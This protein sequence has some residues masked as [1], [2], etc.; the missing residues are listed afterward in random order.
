[1]TRSARPDETEFAPHYA[2][3]VSRV[4]DGDII[5][6]LRSQVDATISLARSLAE[7]KGARRYAPGKWSVREVLGHLADTERIMA[8]RALRVARGDATPLAGFDENA[9]VENARFDER[10][11][12]SLA[13]DLAV[14]RQATLALLAPLNDAEF[15]RSGSANGAPVTVRALAWIIAGHE[16]HHLAMLRERYL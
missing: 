15:R 4:P 10:T 3:Y 5:E 16:R 1:M 2:A 8:Y 6:T 9:F 14:A 13:D 7:E 12:S 11:L